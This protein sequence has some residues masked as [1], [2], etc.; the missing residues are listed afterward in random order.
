MPAAPDDAVSALILEVASQFE[1]A[2]A[3]I[4]LALHVTGRRADGYH[5]LDSLVVFADTADTLKAVPRDEALVKVTLDGQFADDLDRAGPPRDN[6]V[7]R[8]A[9]ELIA[10]FPGRPIRGVRIDLTKRLPVAAGLGGGSA[11]AAAALRLLDRLWALGTG[12]EML[13]EIGLRLG[14][15]VP[16]CLVSRPLRAEGIGEQVRLVAGIPELPL[17]LVNPGIALPTGAVFRRLE[18]SEGAPMWPVP[19]RFRSLIEFAQWLRLSRNDLFPAAQA[20]AKIV[21][22]VVKAVSS[23]PE[24]LIARMSGSGATVFGIFNSHAAAERAAARIH[25]AKPAWWV[26]V[27]RSGGS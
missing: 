16:A 25:A 10:A 3:K 9:N 5:L 17:I 27:T 7:I 18:S 24:C 13:A 21:G 14:A 2:R 6:L 1:S 22:T 19:P 15:D 26:A 12:R 20:E 8:A 11:D 23:D 4:N